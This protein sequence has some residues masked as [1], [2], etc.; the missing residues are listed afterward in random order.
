MISLCKID[1][2]SFDAIVTAIQEKTQIL[3]GANSGVA[4]SRDREIRDITGIKIG[5]VITF[6]PDADPVAFDELY[7]YLFGSIRES[8]FIEAVHGQKTILYEAAYNTCERSVSRIDKGT[9][10]DD[11]V[12]AWGGL[13]VEF[14][15]I[16]NQ[17]NPE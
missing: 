17:I 11:E 7:E 10:E 3:E 9:D 5:H 13:T 2:M 1:G 4:I 12:V 15:P 6:D 16:E 8:V 14:R